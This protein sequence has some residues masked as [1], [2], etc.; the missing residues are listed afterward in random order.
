MA[1]LADQVLLKMMGLALTV[2]VILDATIVRMLLV[3]AMMTIAGKWNWWPGA[4][5]WRG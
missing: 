5:R 2:G 3:P 4:V 1:A